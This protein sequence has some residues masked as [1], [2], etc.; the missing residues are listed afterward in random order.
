[1]GYDDLLQTCLLELFEAEPLQ[2]SRLLGD[3]VEGDYKHAEDWAWGQAFIAC[4]DDAARR[5]CLETEIRRRPANAIAQRAL[6][7]FEQR[8]G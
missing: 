1:M 3:I 5:A 7:L 6:A 4:P 8:G 2:A